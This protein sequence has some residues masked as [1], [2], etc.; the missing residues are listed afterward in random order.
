[1]R[2]RGQSQPSHRPAREEHLALYRA[3]HTAGLERANAAPEALAGLY[4]A[5]G[6]RDRDGRI[7]GRSGSRSWL[8]VEAMAQ[9]QMTAG[10]RSVF[11]TSELI[12]I[13]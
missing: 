11:L 4:L 10:E 2:Q 7:S 9:S 8:T 3:F 12:Q 5:T 13:T 1:M 6:T